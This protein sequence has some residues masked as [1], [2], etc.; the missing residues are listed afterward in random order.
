MSI[1]P[2]LALTSQRVMTSRG[3]RSG[4]ILIRGEKILDVVSIQEIPSHC[5]VEDMG[6]DV[7]MPGLVD[8]HVHINEP[9]RTDWEGFKTATKAAAAGGITTLV[10][11]PLNSIPVTTTVDALKQKLLVT[12]DQ[13]WVDCGFY[14]GL[15]PGNLQDLESL[16][17]AGVLGFKAFLSHSGID[18]FPNI[19]E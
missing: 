2:T 15:I 8:T 14:G 7:I 18:E 1:S 3:E 11:M 10:D 13:L 16:A 17:D 9:G 6:N 5:L 12:Q 4:A 19:T